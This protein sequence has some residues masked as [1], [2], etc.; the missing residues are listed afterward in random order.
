MNTMYNYVYK[1]AENKYFAREEENYYELSNTSLEDLFGKDIVPNYEKHI[2]NIN[3]LDINYI[4]IY[5]LNDLDMIGY[6]DTLI[7]SF[8]VIEFFDII[9]CISEKHEIETIIKRHFE[10]IEYELALNLNEEKPLVYF[11]SFNS[12]DIFSELIKKLDSK[13]NTIYYYD[14]LKD[15]MEISYFRE[16]VYSQE[17]SKNLYNS[18]VD[19]HYSIEATRYSVNKQINPE[20][21]EGRF[22]QVFNLKNISDVDFIN[23]PIFQCESARSLNE[24]QYSVHGGKGYDIEQSKLSAIGEA[25]ERYS[26]RVFGYEKVIEET[27]YKMRKKYNTLNPVALFLDKDYI[28]PYSVDKKYQW[29]KAINLTTNKICYVPCNTVYFPYNM[30]EKYM[31]HSQST[32]GIASG[33]NYEDAIL[34]GI[35]EVIERDAYAITH[36]A[37]INAKE[38]LID[39]IANKTTGEL[40]KIIKKKGYKI[41]LKLL[42]IDYNCYVVHCIL[43]GKVFPIYAH[44]SGAS[45]DIYTA[46]NRAVLESIQM[47]TSQL[48]IKKSNVTY[49]NDIYMKWGEGHKEYCNIFLNEGNDEQIETTKLN[50]YASQNLKEDIRNIISILEKEK[51]TVLCAD[52]SR[53]DTP[54]KTVRIIIPGF[55]D[56]DNYNTRDTLRLKEKLK[57]KKKNNFPLFS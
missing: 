52:L 46:I 19:R 51:Y 8:T 48:L 17:E 18:L 27:Y 54:L 35:L 31:L 16:I 15:K 55:Q 36:K 43:E 22:G 24:L 44:G 45:L 53:K 13:H 33:I 25:I 28:N 42:S 6:F 57:N 4:K 26:A 29:T 49:S 23:I 21:Y 20:Q 34:Q 50:K 12:K 37:R 1:I 56:I 47:R 41:H 40:L 30:E 9:V 39:K 7:D 5:K 3:N 10:T 32:T 38:I 2:L 11:E 14:K